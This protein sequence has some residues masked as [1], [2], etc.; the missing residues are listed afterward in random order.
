MI[1]SVYMY[2]CVVCIVS[3]QYT[4]EVI[5]LGFCRIEHNV[6]VGKDIQFVVAYTTQTAS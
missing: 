5:R 3:S 4:V 2:M 6:T 1:A